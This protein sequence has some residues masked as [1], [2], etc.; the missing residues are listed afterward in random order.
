[1]TTITKDRLEEMLAGLEGVT[2]GPW[3]RHE[4]GEET[5]IITG[6]EHGET[7][8]VVPWGRE[9]TCAHEMGN[10]HRDASHIARCDPD[11]MRQIITLALQ[12]LRGSGVGVRVK[13]LE[14]GRDHVRK[15]WHGNVPYQ[16]GPGYTVRDD[17]GWRVG[18]GPW[19]HDQSGDPASARDACQR[20]FNARILSA[21]AGDGVLSVADAVAQLNAAIEAE[22]RRNAV[23]DEMLATVIVNLEKSDM[24]A[25]F[26][27]LLRDYVR[28]ERSKL[29]ALSPTSREGM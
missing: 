7:V 14:W 24:T 19:V 22:N 27:V 21:I 28:S 26:A 20:D 2:P 15:T 1:M 13:P 16:S 11:T 4:P 9:I 12:S 6:D 5:L 25:E 29:A 3:E 18:D 10:A 8:A 23:R 17:G